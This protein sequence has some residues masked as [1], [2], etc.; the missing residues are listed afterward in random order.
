MLGQGAYLSRGQRL[1]GLRL[2]LVVS[3]QD[4]FQPQPGDEGPDLEVQHQAD[5][6]GLVPLAGAVGAGGRLDRRVGADGA[7]GI[8]E[9]GVGFVGFQVGPLAGLDGRVVQMLIDAFQA[10][11]LLDQG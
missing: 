1:F 8:A 2:G 4:V 7:E 3:R 10:A 5:G 9:L 6:G 11:E